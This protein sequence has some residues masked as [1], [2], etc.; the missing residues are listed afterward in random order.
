MGGVE[1][2]GRGVEGEGTGGV[3]GVYT[4]S[5]TFACGYSSPLTHLSVLQLGAL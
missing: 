1:G 5:L 2:R 3:E 4:L